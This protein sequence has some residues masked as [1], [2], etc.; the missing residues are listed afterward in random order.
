MATKGPSLQDQFLGKLRDE[1]SEVSIFL[2]NGIRLVGRIIGFDA[3][4]II[5]DNQGLQTIYKSAIST[6]SIGGGPAPGSKPARPGGT[7]RKP[8]IIRKGGSRLGPSS[9]SS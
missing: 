2:V 5:L 9:S 1:K 3:Y 4:M 8:T 7:D 6:I